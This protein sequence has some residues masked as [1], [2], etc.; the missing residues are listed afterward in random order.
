MTQ[1]RKLSFV[2]RQQKK[3]KQQQKAEKMSNKWFPTA[4]IQVTYA[5]ITK[6]I[7]KNRNLFVEKQ[8]LMRA[9]HT[10]K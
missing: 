9:W 7:F 5:F 1:K 10:Y 4:F 6:M 3:I 2:F 8:N